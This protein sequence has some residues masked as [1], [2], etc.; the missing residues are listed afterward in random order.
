MSKTIVLMLFAM[1]LLNSLVMVGSAS[2]QSVPKPSVPEFT[3]E[4]VAHPYYVPPTYEIDPYTGEEV[5]TAEGYHVENKSVEITIKNQP[6]SYFVNG[7]NAWLVYNVLVKGHF[8]EYGSTLYW[9][10]QYTGGNLPRQSSSG[11]T[12]I[13]VPADEYPMGGEVDFQVQAISVYETQITV[14]PHIISSAGAYNV[15]G[16]AIGEFGDWSDFQTLKIEEVQV[17]SP[18]PESTP[19]PTD[20][21]FGPTSPPGQELLL[22]QEQLVIL[23]LTVTVAVLAVVVCLLLCLIK[24]KR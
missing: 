4:L 20:P 19:T 17:S 3:L 18:S 2:A 12:V 7:S 5:L 15:M 22:T 1:L 10:N 9:F 23:G 8:E 24:R 14:Y 6:Y 21:N 11:Y 13:S 16:Y